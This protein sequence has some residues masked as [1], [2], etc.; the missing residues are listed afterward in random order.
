[1]VD[2]LCVLLVRYGAEFDLDASLDNMSEWK[3]I[4]K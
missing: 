3:G 1:M 4:W 2:Y